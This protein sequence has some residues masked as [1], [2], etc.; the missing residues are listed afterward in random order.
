MRKYLITILIAF[1]GLTFAFP[2]TYQFSKDGKYVLCKYDKYSKSARLIEYDKEFKM[3][4]ERSFGFV[5]NEFPTDQYAVVDY[6]YDGKYVF[7]SNN[8][9][10][11]LY[12]A[13]TGAKVKE[14]KTDSFEKVTNGRFAA[15]SESGNYIMYEKAPSKA[16]PFSLQFINIKTGNEKEFKIKG[17]KGSYITNATLSP[18]DKLFALFVTTPG[19]KGFDKKTIMIIDFETQKV[20]SQSTKYDFGYYSK[21]EFTSDIK[22][23]VY[24]YSGSYY[25]ALSVPALKEVET[26]AI[27]KDGLERINYNLGRRGDGADYNSQKPNAYNIE[28]TEGNVEKGF[29]SKNWLHIVPIKVQKAFFD[30]SGA[31]ANSSSASL[32]WTSFTISDPSTNSICD[33]F[34]VIRNNTGK[35]ELNVFDTYSTRVVGKDINPETESG[36]LFTAV[37]NFANRSAN[38]DLQA[39]ERG[40]N[41]VSE[42]FEDDGDTIQAFA[43]NLLKS[44]MSFENPAKNFIADMT[45]KYKKDLFEGLNERPYLVLDNKKHLQRV[46]K[47]I[48]TK[49]GKEIIT[50]SWDKTIRVW[51]AANGELK[52]IIRMPA[53][54]GIEG[55]IYAMALSPDGKYLAV[56]GV[57]PGAVDNATAMKERY[58]GDC[59]YLIDYESGTIIDR[60]AWHVQNIFSLAF[61]DKGSLLASGGGTGDNSVW[62]YRIT[63]NFFQELQPGGGVMM[64]DLVI[65]ITPIIGTD[66]F[67]ACDLSGMAVHIE[68]IKFDDKGNLLQKPIGDAVAKSLAPQ[69][70]KTLSPAYYAITSDPSGK[71]TALGMSYGVQIIGVNAVNN[72]NYYLSGSGFTMNPVFAVAFSSDSKRIAVA[73]GKEVRVFDGLTPDDAAGEMKAKELSQF[74]MHDNN[75]LAVAYSPDGKY[76]ASSGGDAN[77]V[78]VWEAATGKLVY[79]LGGSSSQSN[80]IWALG[81]HKT[82]PN[83]IGFGH[84]I[85]DWTKLTNNHGKITKAFD[86]STLSVINNP[87]P[88]DFLTAYSENKKNSVT[89]PSFTKDITTGEMRCYAKIKDGGYIIGSEFGLYYKK[90]ST[91]YTLNVSGITTNAVASGSDNKYFYAGLADG[92]IEMYSQDTREHIAS[93]FISSDNEWILWTPEGYYTASKHGARMAG[94][95]INPWPSLAEKN[96][97]TAFSS[98]EK[99]AILRAMPDKDPKYYPF[100]QFDIRLNRPD[101]VLSKLGT[102]DAMQNNALK[103]AYAKRL[104]KLGINKKN[105]SNKIALPKVEI[106]KIPQQTNEK[107]ISVTIKVKDDNFSI[108]SINIAANDVPI[109]GSNGL[110]VEKEKLGEVSKNIKIELTTG[111]NKI[112]ISAINSA[113]IESDKETFYINYNGKPAARSCYIVAIGVSDYADDNFDLVY[114]SKDA[115]DVASFFESKKA[116]FAAVK[117]LKILDKNATRENILKAKEFLAQSKVDDEAIVFFAGHGLLDEKLDYYLATSD[118]NFEKPAERGVSYEELESLLDGIPARQ[119]LL[120][121]DACHSGEIDKEE[122][123]LVDNTDN[124]VEGVISR[125]LKK[126]VEKSPD[127]S[128]GLQNS[129]KLMGQ[130]FADLSKGAGAVVISSASGTEFSYESS[131]WKN[132]VFTYALLEGLK[133]SAADKNKDKIFSISEVRDYTIDKVVNLTKGKQRPTSRKENI[134]FDYNLW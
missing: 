2:Q 98:K 59:V 81:S 128:L 103:A 30:N 69:V 43:D 28:K 94:W 63:D 115:G 3:K 58:A 116:Q 55:Q 39:K 53:Y 80:R 19:N 90:D 61:S 67:M 4:D 12:E 105:L 72:I 84:T 23:I 52:R 27:N 71:W 123:A 15:F 113:G 88:D 14:Y 54:P 29:G 77:Q 51:D 7:V 76:I 16:S 68:T 48:Y 130:L 1:L 99:E 73:S 97:F 129:F 122:I 18:D 95:L 91:F 13:I 31:V 83:I 133:T 132:G 96:Q 108:R 109:F 60:T 124:A 25:K 37:I 45:K 87:N 75:V 107:I 125:G 131:E 114:A 101:I 5:L 11:T 38:V 20:L 117:V 41:I 112:Q 82:N 110:I 9:A 40:S 56:A 74:T 106:S 126:V 78:Y 86:L 104:R 100:E 102:I 85:D 26:S 134:E 44:N 127:S 118:L 120:L 47:I 35:Y 8:N 65:G 50:G 10:I 93:L 111:R 66:K 17:G 6:S 79:E 70:F 89:S 57:A 119:K 62:M 22:H 21:P 49:N 92:R 121:M 33:D 32:T 34:A 46:S 36:K 24:Q 64:N 42:A